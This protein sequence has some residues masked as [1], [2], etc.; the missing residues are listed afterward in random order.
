MKR[1]LTLLF[2]ILASVA[3]A[4][5]DWW[6]VQP[7]V[8]RYFLN[9]Y[10]YLRGM[11]VDSVKAIGSNT[12]LY[13]FKS[14]RGYYLSNQ[15]LKP[16]GSWL[17]DTII[18]APD[19]THYFDNYWG[20]TVV[21]KSQAALNDS[22][23]LYNDAT[24]QHYSATV[25][26]V[27]TAT[28]LGA[29]DEIKDITITAWN[30]AAVNSDDPLH[31]T[32]II[33]SKNHGFVRVPDLYLFPMHEP[34]QVYQR[35]FDFW[36]DRDLPFPITPTASQLYFNL[37]DLPNPNV[38]NIYDFKVGD[39]FEYKTDGV[40]NVSK[41]DLEK[42]VLEEVVEKTVGATS[43][44]YKI[45]RWTYTQN[46]KTF[47]PSHSTVPAYV[48]VN[49]N[50]ALLLDTNYMPEEWGQK[51]IIRYNPLD[52][53]FC[54]TA[55]AYERLSINMQADSSLVT[56]EPCGY[57]YQYKQK[58]GRTLYH[59]CWDKN[60]GGYY[61]T[62]LLHTRKNGNPCY[63][64]YALDVEQS[65][66]AELNIYPNPASDQLVVNLPTAG[67]ATITLHNAVGQLVK[68]IQTRDRSTSIEVTDLPAG[69]YHI[70][71]LQNGERVIDKVLIEH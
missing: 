46:F 63:R 55:P 43:V 49:Y 5:T 20:D 29:L 7:S 42:I 24:A 52:T 26:A 1:T 44:Q 14:A 13:P 17:G 53:T 39:M 59:T 2:I 35:G 4:Q 28:V 27:N 33:L 10:Y 45:A 32:K 71:I 47:P 70:S 23:E 61:R 60:F 18:I 3:Q 48:T 31:N 54:E 58:L 68:Q 38:L 12:V 15:K 69:L 40:E 51:D 56:M 22:W 11:R 34:D 16:S 37:I 19:G 67:D 50:S 6:C 66:K 41:S 62:Q 21:I 57:G 9:D 64:Y 65:A 8:K 30:G 25:T 36:I